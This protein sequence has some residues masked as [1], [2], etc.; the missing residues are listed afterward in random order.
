MSSLELL[1]T[2]FPIF[3]GCWQIVLHLRLCLHS[4][5]TLHLQTCKYITT[6]AV[7]QNG[8]FIPLVKFS[9]NQEI[10]QRHF[11]STSKI[12]HRLS[13]SIVGRNIHMARSQIW[14][15]L[16]GLCAQVVLSSYLCQYHCGNLF[17]LL[18][19][20]L[21]KFVMLMWWLDDAIWNMRSFLKTLG[22]LFLILEF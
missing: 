15:I 2:I 5:L 1:I 17:K 3:L 20:T 13:K 21:R 7:L 18:G 22:K 6:F 4:A 8:L 19:L 10:K 11:Y 16:S 12:A 14:K 9:Q